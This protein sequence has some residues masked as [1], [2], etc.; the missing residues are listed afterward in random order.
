M[1]QKLLISGIFALMVFGAL[2]FFI[3]SSGRK[4]GGVKEPGLDRNESR[5]PGEPSTANQPVPTILPQTPS[6]QNPVE[7]PVEKPEAPGSS[8]IAGR[9]VEAEGGAPLAGVT[10]RASLDSGELAAGTLLWKWEA[11]TDARGGFKFRETEWAPYRVQASL[12]GRLSALVGSVYPGE[13]V[14]LKLTVQQAIPLTLVLDGE[15]GLTPLPHQPVWI[16]IPGVGWSFS[17]ESDGDGSVGLTGVPREELELARKSHQIECL[18]PGFA[19]A[20]FSAVPPGDSYRISVESAATLEGSVLDA[21]TKRPIP[22]ARVHADS[23]HEVTADE[24]GRYRISG[25]ADDVTAYA[26]GYSFETK[27]VDADDPGQVVRHDFRLTRGLTLRG[28]VSDAKGRPLPGFR[29]S[30]VFD[31]L[32]LESSSEK[33][34][35]RLIELSACVSGTDGEY[36]LEGLDPDA[37]ALPGDLELSVKAPGSESSFTYDVEGVSA[38][39]AEV[40]RDIVLDLQLLLEGIVKLSS[41]EFLA[42]AAVYL[43]SIDSDF[44]L[45]SGTN[46]EGSFAFKN[47]PTSRYRLRVVS[48]GRVVHIQEV[49]IPAPPLDI[50]A[51]AA[52]TVEGL[53]F[54]ADTREPLASLQLSLVTDSRGR[55]PVASGV[56][57]DMTGRFR[58]EDV[59]RGEYRL[60]VKQDPRTAA[61]SRFEPSL[62]LSISASDEGWKGDLAVPV[63]PS[64]EVSLSFTL[65]PRPG[66]VAAPVT[67]SVWI[68]FTSARPPNSLLTPSG[69]GDPILVEDPRLGYRARWRSGQYKLRFST[70][71]EGKLLLKDEVFTVASGVVLERVV[72][73]TR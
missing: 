39:L 9:V 57:T 72:T 38:S 37:L 5:Q 42:R 31:A 34:E 48:E 25:V 23:G 66:E 65:S 43:E 1:N 17:G 27:E 62:E 40:E 3:V 8:V 56:V 64:G 14:E 19:E 70:T 18:V 49:D 33:L 69:G 54:A 15:E 46:A 51:L 61:I 20:T 50:R 11:T 45:V 24:N 6:K 67:S 7:P 71:V 10:V 53:L 29:I 35:S 36:L 12:V 2:F 28:K 58:F 52:G 13:D 60:L 68:A 16:S 4:P 63:L 21:Q 47:V 59:P 44:H 32:A 26:P 41:G 73:F 22:G 30:I 55:V